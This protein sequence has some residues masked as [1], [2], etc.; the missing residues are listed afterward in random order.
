[1]VYNAF[2]SSLKDQSMNYQ[3]SIIELSFNE[4]TSFFFLFKRLINIINFF[5]LILKYFLLPVYLSRRLKT[6]YD[7]EFFLV[8]KRCVCNGVYNSTDKSLSTYYYICSHY[9]NRHHESTSTSGNYN[10][11]SAININNQ[12]TINFRII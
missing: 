1:M 6:P 7:A 3:Y 4:W 8:T 12:L 5:L 2:T 9:T 11:I 10:M